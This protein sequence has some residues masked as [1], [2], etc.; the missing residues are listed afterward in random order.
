MGMTPGPTMRPII[1]GMVG[2][3]AA[4]KTTLSRGIAALLGQERVAVLCTDDYH[5]YNRRERKEHNITPL[6]PKCNNLDIMAQHLRLLRA[7]EP[8]LK[9]QYNHSVGDFGPPQYVKPQPFLIVEGLLGFYW[10]E[11]RSAYSVMVYLDPHEDQRRRWKIQ[12]DTTKR[13][14]TEEELLRDLEKREPDSAAF[15]RPQRE[16][17]DI[18]ISFYPN[19]ESCWTDDEHLNVRLTLRGTLRHP[20]F[21]SVIRE[22]TSGCVRSSLGREHGRAV[23]YIEIDGAI[24]DDAASALERCILTHLNANGDAMLD[25]LGEYDYNIRS[26][27]GHSHP[28]AITQLL[29]VYHLL[30]AKQR[31]EGEL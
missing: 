23:E 26:G 18:V 1:L 24:P 5:R 17:A 19:E 29:L 30:R 31:D 6:H 15:I 21:Y 8:V 3:S 25:Y 16:H 28:L 12:R 10:Q 7:G 11:M 22:D 9:P 20:D 4:G 2:D 14:Y 27:K 13:G